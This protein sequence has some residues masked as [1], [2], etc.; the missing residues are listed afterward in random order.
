MTS[1]VKF[2]VKRVEDFQ[3]PPEKSQE[4]LW[5]S[6]QLGLLLRATKGG[7]KSFAFE[8]RLHGKTL[9]I[10]IGDVRT[11]TVGKAQIEAARLKSLTDQGID[12]RQVIA[13]KIAAD[14]IKATE[15]KQRQITESATVAD[16]WKDYVIERSAS[17]RDGK[18]EWGEKHKHHHE[19]FVQAG[20]VKRI[21][22]QRPG[23]PDTT[24]PGIL[25][26]L[27]T[28]R[29]IDLDSKAVCAWLDKEAPRVPAYT[30]QAF[31]ALRAFVNWCAKSD[32]YKAATNADA[33]LIDE[34]KRR[35]PK[36]KA[37]KN[38]SL[39]KAQLKPWFDAVSKISNPVISAYLQ[40]LLLIGARRNELAG[41]RWQDVDFQWKS[42]TIRDKVEGER[43]IPLT[44]Y[45]ESL[46]L[47]LKRRNDTRP[48]INLRNKDDSEQA[49][50][51]KPSPWVF[52]SPTSASGRLESPV[53]RH[54]QALA[55]AGLP[56]VTL[57]GLRRS[58]ST[59]AEWVEVPAGVVAQIMGH[60][61]SAIAEKHYIQRELDILHL[62]HAKVEVWILNE[63]GVEFVPAQSA[64]R[65]A[66][67]NA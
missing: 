3:C 34:V 7:A 37:K 55:A 17:T 53:K 66:V 23:Q 36:S 40:I 4:F 16:A 1:K 67:N 43:T 51:W 52:S 29:L 20:G 41:L 63:A 33:C 38:D 24:R 60:K 21:S 6:G 61:P 15:L 45:V 50:E 11:W 44:P 30:E 46:L 64:L 12:P 32:K 25:V 42:L 27:M 8:S 39:R 56:Q 65:V 22:G 58:F 5:D 18:P 35:V 9:R 14:E 10:T 13:E 54:N 57:H 26:P 49:E 48:V 62:W 59:L 31:R 2:T 47:N 28:L 19:L